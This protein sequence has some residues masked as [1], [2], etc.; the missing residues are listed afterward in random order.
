MNTLYTGHCTGAEV[1]KAQVA[2]LPEA[3]VFHTGSVIE[4]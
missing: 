1:K 2:E 3:R 4:F